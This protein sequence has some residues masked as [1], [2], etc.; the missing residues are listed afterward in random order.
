MNIL[1]YI[2][3]TA[4]VFGTVRKA[5]K[6]GADSVKIEPVYT[7]PYCKPK[8]GHW[9][10]GTAEAHVL[11]RYPEIYNSVRDAFQ[12]L[13]NDTQYTYLFTPKDGSWANRMRFWQELLRPVLEP[14][15]YHETMGIILSWA[16]RCA[17]R[18]A[19]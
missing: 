14:R 7:I 4:A 13:D 10:A 2:K 18:A 3:T 9:F 8:G 16:I 19:A 1:Q 5:G 11:A 17:R 15:Q 6:A 12:T